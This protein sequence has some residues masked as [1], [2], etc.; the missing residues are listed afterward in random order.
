[1]LQTRTGK[2]TAA[3]ALQIAVDMVN[4]GLIDKKTAVMRVEPEQID[5]LLHK[6]LDK[7]AQEKAQ[8]IARGLPAS[9]GA[10]VG[11]VVFNAE[12][13]VEEA[14]KGK[15]V[16]LVRTE[17]SPEDIEGMAN[18]QGILTARGGMTHHAPVVQGG[19]GKSW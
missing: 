14:K 16:I 1:M 12:D 19:R 18:A 8:M 11:M 15:K 2:R 3:A 5:Q 17:T 13:A 6:Q 4:E 9:P 10:A 7:K